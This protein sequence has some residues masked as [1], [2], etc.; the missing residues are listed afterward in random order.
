MS[1]IDDFLARWREYREPGYYE[2]FD[3]HWT[4]TIDL[5][6]CTGCGACVT[7]CQAENNLPIVGE[8]AMA[9]GR[10]MQWLR[11]ERY[12]EG[13]YPD[14]KLLNVLLFKNQAETDRLH[15][16]LAK[17]G[18]EV[19]PEVVEATP[20]KI[21]LKKT[22]TTPI[23]QVYAAAAKHCRD[24]GKKSIFINSASPIY[25]YICK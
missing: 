6:R 8:D 9:R 25:E 4:M 1:F 24:L 2:E 5:D 14:I 20:E 15:K 21:V 19:P 16:G 12:W 22:P 11:I 17:L 10:E 23:A 13:D 7:A 3:Y 18:Y